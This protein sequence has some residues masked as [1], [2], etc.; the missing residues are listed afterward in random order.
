METQRK[1]GWKKSRIRRAVGEYMTFEL[2]FQRGEEIH[3]K[4]E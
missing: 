4:K 3:E 2:I 1:Q